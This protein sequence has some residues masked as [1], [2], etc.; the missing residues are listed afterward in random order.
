[1]LRIDYGNS[2]TYVVTFMQHRSKWADANIIYNFGHYGGNVKT[3]LRFI[4]TVKT[5]LDEDRKDE[6]IN[7]V[8]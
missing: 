3:C 8:N 7:Y 4:L 6:N 1:M 5:L 2:V